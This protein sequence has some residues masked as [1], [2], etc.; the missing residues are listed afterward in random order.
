LK[1]LKNQKIKDKLN[2]MNRI[3]SRVTPSNIKSMLMLP[4][5]AIVVGMAD[6]AHIWVPTDTGLKVVAKINYQNICSLSLL[7]DGNLIFMRLYC[8]SLFIWDT[9]ALGVKVL[10]LF[11]GTIVRCYLVLK[12]GI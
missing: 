12:S 3:G 4:G 9:T 1:E 11:N 6:N 10:D 7:P 2:A 5:G 8:S